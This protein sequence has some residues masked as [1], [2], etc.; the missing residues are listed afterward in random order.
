M[1]RDSITL[2][3]GLLAWLVAAAPTGMAA[4]APGSI[5]QPWAE[6]SARWGLER[7]PLP[8][9]SPDVACRGRGV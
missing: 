5:K 8:A 1:L 9:G 7:S 4:Q 3:V 6:A 2:S